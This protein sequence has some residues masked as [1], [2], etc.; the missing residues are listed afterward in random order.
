MQYHDEWLK[1]EAADELDEL[2]HRSPESEYLFYRAVATGDVEAVRENCKLGKFLE[3]DGVGTLS[4]NPVTNLKYHFVVTAA[5]ITRICWQNGME[6]ERTYR[7]SDFYIQKLD[8]AHTME[9]VRRVHDSMVLDFAEN[10]RRLLNKPHS[11]HI[12][13]CKE[14]IYAHIKERITVEDLAQNLGVS[15]SYLS[16]MFKKET[17]E[18]ISAYI[19]GKKIAVAENLL[20]YTDHSM[21][22]IAN[23]LSFSSE[24]HFIQQFREVVG[25]T[26]KKY[27]DEN[28]L[29]RWDDGAK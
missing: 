8:D 13:A 5:M 16:R 1:K 3:L 7:L 27:R 17:G 19:R 4:R 22:E 28:F 18:S 15:T 2:Y 25:T 21:I 20:K 10:M 12:R 24:S 9:D 29:I 23:L 26:P 14:Y 6:M 11:R